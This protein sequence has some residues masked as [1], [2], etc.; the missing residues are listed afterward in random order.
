MLHIIRRSLFRLQKLRNVPGCPAAGNGFA[1]DTG[2]PSDDGKG[3]QKPRAGKHPADSAKEDE[4]KKSAAALNRLNE[5]LS[6]M[7]TESEVKL[8]KKVDLPRPGKGKTK[9]KER[10]AAATDFSDSDDERPKDLAHATRNVANALGGDTKRTEAELLSKLL[11]SSP[12]GGDNGAITNI[13][14]GMSVDRDD[15]ER[16]PVRD[17][18]RSTLVKKVIERAKKSRD[19]GRPRAAEPSRNE[20]SEGRFRPPRKQLPT[21]AGG[22]GSVQLFGEEPLG[23]LTELESLKEIPDKLPTWAKLHERELKLTVTHP[24]ANHFQKMALWTE[25]GKLWQFPID[26]EQGRDD[27]RKVSFTEHVFLEE[28]LE[29]W[30]PKKG[31]IRHFME[32]VC[33]G[34]SKNHYITAQAKRDHI[35]WFR[36]Y[37]EQ[38]KDLLK[39]IIVQETNKVKEVEK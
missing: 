25:Q 24:P 19:D 28:H 34:L 36:D 12:T 5:L 8:V 18:A 3:K 15:R 23:I 14:S 21:A 30:C 38:K 33:V 31:P 17:T 13:I 1:S 37:F 22:P 10:K 29:G 32:L 35:F 39:E 2:A 9:A 11:D 26:N 27:D 16:E 4:G 6:M 20:R 7:N